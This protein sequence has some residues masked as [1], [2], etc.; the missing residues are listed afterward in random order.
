MSLSMDIIIK[1]LEDVPDSC[2][3]LLE[4]L[5]KQSLFFNEVSKLNIQH[6]ISRT[7][8]LV[9]HHDTYRK[10]FGINLIKVLAS[11]YVILANEGKT[12][13]KELVKILESFL[14]SW[15][16]NI[17]SS[18]IDC[19]EY[20][21]ERIRGKPTL[22]R[23]IV[24]PNL[25]SVIS[26]LMDK[27][28]YNPTTIIPSL[29]LLMKNHPTT[30]RPFGNKLRSKLMELLNKDTFTSFPENLKSH[31]CTAIA[32]LPVV[33]K[34]EPEGKWFLDTAYLVSEITEVLMLYDQFLN[35]S[36]DSNLSDNL[37]RLAAMNQNTSEAPFEFSGLKID[38]GNPATIYKISDRL[39][40]L[41]FLL[42]HFLTTETPFSVRV[43][44]GKIILLCE[45]ICSVNPRFT[46]FRK[47][48]F[49]DELRNVISGS[50]VRN[51]RNVLKLLIDITNCYQGF[52]LPHSRSTI[53]FI[54]TLLPLRNKKINYRDVLIN[55]SLMCLI[56]ESV[57]GILG[58]TS[59]FSSGEDISRFIELAILLIE[60]RDSI[61]SNSQSNSLSTNVTGG[62]KQKGSRKKDNSSA[63]SDLLSHQQLFSENVPSSTTSVVRNFFKIIIPRVE[64]NLT[65]KHKIAKYLM[66]EAVLSSN[67]HKDKRIDRE[68]E[69]LLV[70]ACLN[71]GKE[72]TSLTPI[73]ANI[74]RH[75]NCLSLLMNPRLPPLPQ[76]VKGQISSEAV[77]YENNTSDVSEDENVEEYPNAES[78]GKR[79]SPYDKASDN[80]D[81]PETKRQ[82][83]ESEATN[84]ASIPN[85]IDIHS[86]K[87]QSTIKN[88][89][90]EP[91]ATVSTDY[92]RKTFS[93]TET[94]S[95]VDDS[96]N[97]YEVEKQVNVSTKVEP[98]SQ[99][100][101][102]NSTLEEGD[103]SSS[104]I[105]IPDIDVG[106]DSDE[107]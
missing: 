74:I 78:H 63:L 69:E 50:I 46:T 61:S 41:L 90:A 42:K 71:P 101:T 12:F 52:I 49:S 31:I 103:Q 83:I 68:L 105:E 65:Q 17:L 15:P 97:G 81:E 11:N 72:S 6:L 39:E 82:K 84:Q 60:P 76:V 96:K 23:E 21:F 70:T 57:S 93:F 34:N 10:W 62:K 80:A 18:A 73:V 5:H 30:F 66:A 25:P 56:L 38:L 75:N 102:H 3:S 8:K 98:V 88:D 54:E 19:V 59:E 95:A 28:V 44:L 22:T 87:D 32:S 51:Q 16:L 104:D 89:A 86:H 35:F 92:T 47:D 58:L 64:I 9:R 36:L 43:P 14:T 79:D 53:A 33:E 13:I 26:S 20:I 1:E 67:K 85:S 2:V 107:E 77:D 4:S 45:N 106:S 94:G 29:T 37:K 27:M 55:E 24:T 48:V 91:A 100:E 40:T 99:R 7:L